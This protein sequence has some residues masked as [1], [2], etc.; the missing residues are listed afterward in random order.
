M[1]LQ[2]EA[3]V[4]LKK[5]F[6]YDSFRPNQE[7]IISSV[8]SGQDT[9]AVMPTGGGKSIC[10]QLPAMLKE[11]MAIVISPLIALMKDQVDAL[12]ANGIPARYFNS[13]LSASEENH[14][15]NEARK[16]ELKLLY[17]SP[18]RLLTVSFFNFLKQ[19]KLNLF[20]VDEAHCISQWGH[21]FRPE[22]TKLKF[23]KANFPEIPVIALTAT[24]DRLTRKDIK[25]QLMLKEPKLFLASFDRPNLSLEVR[26][27]QRVRDQ[28]L[29]FLEERPNQSGIIY[30]LSKKN[31]ED[32][33]KFLQ[34]NGYKADFYHAGISADERAH[35]QNEFLR[36]NTQIMC[37]TIAF[38]MGIDKSNVRFVIHH[39]LPKNIESYYQEI[40][41]AGRDGLDSD[42]LLFYSYRDVMILEGFIAD[43]G[44]ADIQQAKLDRMKQFA[45]AKT[46]RRRM[47]LSYFGEDRQKDCGNCDVCLDPP[48]QF[49][50]T[51]L[52][53]KALS[54]VV[55]LKEQVSMSLL[56][57]VL[58]GS[59]RQEI[60][61]KGYDKI[62]TY[63]AGRDLGPVVW[64]DYISQMLNQGL[65]ELAYDQ[66]H[67]VRCTEAGREVLFKS[68]S[69]GLAEYTIREKSSVG[70]ER[71]SSKRKTKR[72]LF[73]DGLFERLRDLRKTI[74]GETWLA[75]DAI[76]SDA[77]LK[78]MVKKRP[79]TASGMR[80]VSGMS[81]AKFQNYGAR[82]INEI[83]DYVMEADRDGKAKAIA[84]VT[85]LVTY[86][87]HRKGKAVEEIAKE[88]G[89]TEVTVFSH[90]GQLY[91]MGCY[92]DIF[93]YVEEPVLQR[94][95]KAIEETGEE[96]ALRPLF[97]HLQ[98][99]VPFHQ[100][101]LSLSWWKRN[102]RTEEV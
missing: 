34:K 8:M 69:V 29:D 65:I 80:Q 73:E 61:E 60:L 10:Y 76:F 87:L 11:G 33:S 43:S 93:R 74:A 39:N 1:P 21:D 84:G 88:R 15:L 37:A 63:G 42:T 18:E 38:G 72:E 55:R 98:E 86:A 97:E 67:V 78:D 28:I 44:Q 41:R 31:T 89:M 30:C 99:E 19:L 83:L 92:V 95:V 75:P 2:Q 91:E 45:E 24:A 57:D 71:T 20:A 48:K 52:A 66:N 102:H 4:A 62:K 23:L 101:R 100:I 26:P 59:A 22:Y 17:V 49:D 58:R 47:L 56:I 6:G 35:K 81:E 82:F 9:M 25:T 50:G 7:D 79:V 13:T 14:I 94:V 53:Q 85:H 70:E 90:L 46:C 3:L 40:G 32:L 5:Y 51:Q 27:G 68:R 16:G 96:S 77:T 36:D 12:R 64:L 54:A